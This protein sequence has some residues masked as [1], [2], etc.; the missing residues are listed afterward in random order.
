MDLIKI[1]IILAVIVIIVLR[2]K[3]LYVS[4]SGGIVAI[5]IFY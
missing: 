4:I 5:L 1:T 2:D 3:P